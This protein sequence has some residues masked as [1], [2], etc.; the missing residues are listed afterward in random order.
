MQAHRKDT[1][2]DHFLNFPEI[3]CMGKV[4]I[5]GDFK[6]DLCRMIEEWVED[7]IEARESVSV[8][9]EEGMPGWLVEIATKLGQRKRW[10]LN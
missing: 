3:K 9:K 8:L 10:S 1:V 6:P 4:I 7:P 5:N 2:N